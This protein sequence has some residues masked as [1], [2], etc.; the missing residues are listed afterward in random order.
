MNVASGS[1]SSR[2][3]SWPYRTDAGAAGRQAGEVLSLG[4]HSLEF[5]E[6]PPVNQQSAL[7]LGEG[8]SHLVIVLFRERGGQVLPEPVEMLADDTA[9]FLVAR[10]SMPGVWRR[11]AG[12]GG[13]GRQRRHAEYLVLVGEQPGPGS[14]IVEELVEHRVEG[15]RLGNPPVSL[16]HVQNCVDDLAE[17]LVEGGGRIVAPGLAHAGTDAGLRPPHAQGRAAGLRHPTRATSL[18]QTAG[19]SRPASLDETAQ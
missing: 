5:A 8:R 3:W 14:Q 7:D 18:P 15:V 19:S 4:A 16:L 10:G 11:S 13:L 9:D 1:G 12:G 17:H 6:R 2:R